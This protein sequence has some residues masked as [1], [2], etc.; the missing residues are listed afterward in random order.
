MTPRKTA[1][2]IC[3]LK[4]SDTECFLTCI[5]FPHALFSYI[6]IIISTHIIY[7]SLAFL[8]EKY[9]ISFKFHCTYFAIE[10]ALGPP[11]A[12]HDEGSFQKVSAPGKR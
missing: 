11:G 8:A 10:A 5:I 3:P 2:V 9:L 6:A 4:M 1:H 7:T 12:Q